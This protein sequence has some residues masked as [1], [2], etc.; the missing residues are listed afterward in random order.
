MKVLDEYR[1]AEQRRQEERKGQQESD[2]PHGRPQQRPVGEVTDHVADPRHNEG[3]GE[4]IDHPIRTATEMRYQHRH[5]E[6]RKT[7]EAIPVGRN[8]TRT[9]AVDRRTPNVQKRMSSGRLAKPTTAFPS[10]PWRP[11]ATP[12]F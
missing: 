8:R 2:T 4:E 10:S 12:G 6:G 3:D 1:L 7:F 5:R 11:P 9:P